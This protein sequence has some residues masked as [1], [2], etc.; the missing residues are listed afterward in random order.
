MS[1]YYTQHKFNM[2]SRSNSEDARFSALAQAIEDYG[3]K[4]GHTQ[5]LELYALCPNINHKKELEKVNLLIL[6]M[7]DERITRNVLSVEALQLREAYKRLFELHELAKSILANEIW[8]RNF[9]EYFKE[10]ARQILRNARLE[11]EQHAIREQNRI[12]EL[13]LTL[14]ISLK[15]TFDKNAT[16]SFAI[17]NEVLK[18]AE[19]LVKI[20]RILENHEI[21]KLLNLMTRLSQMDKEHEALKGFIISEANDFKQNPT[22]NIST[23]AE[24]IASALDKLKHYV[25]THPNENNVDLVRQMNNVADNF[26][27]RCDR[28]VNITH[29][30]EQVEKAGNKITTAANEIQKLSTVLEK[31]GKSS[32]QNLDILH[33]A[34]KQHEDKA[35]EVNKQK[36]IVSDEIKKVLEDLKDE[37]EFSSTE[38]SEISALIADINKSQDTINSNL[39]E[40]NK[41]VSE[42]D[43]DLGS[44]N[45][46]KPNN[47]SEPPKFDF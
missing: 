15:N 45:E 18:Q 1:Y 42:L 28:I 14:V 11:D 43:F 6:W 3:Q 38:N 25:T 2:R 41:N 27:A 34:E 37:S 12:K 17:S 20:A 4:N 35:S 32:Q 29:A 21:N 26:Q 9:Q 10:I 23:L 30:A 44:S 19:N 7:T 22:R 33:V 16:L 39:N 40:I 31:A 36:A 8:G 13:Y 46:E 47:E 5:L 24:K